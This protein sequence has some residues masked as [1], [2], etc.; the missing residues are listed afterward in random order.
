MPDARRLLPGVAD[1]VLQNLLGFVSLGSQREFAQSL[2][3]VAPQVDPSAT[4]IALRQHFGIFEGV[5][6]GTRGMADALLNGNRHEA[7]RQGHALG[8]VFRR[9][10]GMGIVGLDSTIAVEGRRQIDERGQALG[11]TPEQINQAHEDFARAA[12]EYGFST[13][14][15][16]SAYSD[17][18]SQ[19][20]FQEM[21]REAAVAHSENLRNSMRDIQEKINSTT[22]A[23]KK[24]QLEEEYRQ[25][26]Q[27]YSR[28]VGGALGSVADR[29]ARGEEPTE[30]SPS[31]RT[32]T[33]NEEQMRQMASDQ[34]TLL[35]RAHM[36]RPGEY[37]PV[38]VPRQA[39]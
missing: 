31:G 3:R 29:F 25:L 13:S 23:R 17:M 24:R 7:D 6:N 21:L 18:A 27:E 15:I 28:L 10:A 9:G 19:G 39:E 14:V 11:K 36:H 16:A 32:V 38:R 37:V 20:P 22:D 1:T 34:A 5:A 8:D 35:I 2:A 26:L 30:R 4:Y 12:V 33:I